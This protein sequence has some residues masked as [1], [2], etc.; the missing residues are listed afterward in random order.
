[1]NYFYSAHSAHFLRLGNKEVNLGSSV[2]LKCLLW[3][4]DGVETVVSLQKSSGEV[5]SPSQ[6][7]QFGDHLSAVFKY[8]CFFLCFIQIVFPLGK[9]RGIVS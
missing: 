3:G 4:H 8:I 2:D 7:Q 5:L 6:K 9:T 1:M